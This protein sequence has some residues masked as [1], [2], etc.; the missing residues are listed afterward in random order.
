MN[1]R[2][3]SAATSAEPDGEEEQVSSSIVTAQSIGVCHGE[4]W[5]Q[6][7]DEVQT[8]ARLVALREQDQAE[9]GLSDHERL[10]R[11]QELA[12]GPPGARSRRYATKPQSAAAALVAIRSEPTTAC[13][14]G[15]ARHAIRRSRRRS[16]ARA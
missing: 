3:P 7:V 2:T 12:V 5:E 16:Q 14:S 10:G 6:T 11:R 9:R 8:V 4:Q 13:T 15:I 1:A